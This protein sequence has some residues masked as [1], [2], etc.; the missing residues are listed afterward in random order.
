MEGIE[1]L[2][3]ELVREKQQSQCDVYAGRV[4]MDDAGPDN[5]LCSKHAE[6]Y[7]L[8]KEYPDGRFYG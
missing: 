3:P 5:Y 6:L 1:G 7:D 8:I 4:D 2:I